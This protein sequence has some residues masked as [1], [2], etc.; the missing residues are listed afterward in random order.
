MRY[1]IGLF[2][3]VGAAV[4]RGADFGIALNEDDS[5]FYGFRPAEAMSLEGLNA[6]VDQYAGTQVK[7]LFLCPNAQ[8]A[9]YRSK[10]FTPVWELNGTQRAP[11]PGVSTQ[12]LANAKLLDE[13]GL[14]AYAVWIARCREKGI[15]PWLSM[16]MND[17]HNVDDPDSFIHSK[18]WREHPEYWRVPGSTTGSWTDRALDY[19]VAEVRA[20][21]MD[22]VKELLERYDP[23]GLE[24]DWMRFGYHFR[25]GHEAE[26]AEILTQFMREARALTKAAAEKRGHSIQLGVRVPTH[27]DAAKGLGMDAVR[28]AEEGLIDRIVAT[29]FWATTDYDIPMELW[30]ERLGEHAKKVRL[31]AGAEILLRAHPGGKA[32]EQDVASA[33]GFAAG[34]LQ[35]GADQIYL[36]NFMDPEPMQGPAGSYQELL[37]GG[38]D[39]EKLARLPQRYPVTYHDTVASG[40]S[41]GAVLPGDLAKGI[42]TTFHVGIVREG[43]PVKLVLGQDAAGL[44]EAGAV[45]VTVNGAV[46]AATPTEQGNVFALPQGSVKAGANVVRVEAEKAVTI[47]WMELRVN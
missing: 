22:F 6:F 35:R 18:F 21:S 37:R 31:C 8:K 15:A 39:A 9:S 40:M 4:V 38:F 27:P 11:E 10:V 16:R 26:G 44:K 5:H 7:E 13:R 43:A 2:V 20:Y 17:L 29:P 32:I 47:D 33:R 12:W 30:R 42:E 23:D 46:C 1:W 45:K 28:W 34:Q 19:G 24:L 36:F 25:P 41:N 14:D 3:V